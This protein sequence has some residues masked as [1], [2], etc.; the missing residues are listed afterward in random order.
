[1]KMSYDAVAIFWKG[2]FMKK[3]FVQNFTAFVISVSIMLVFGCASSVTPILQYPLL[4][5]KEDFA[6]V[7]IKN[8]VTGTKTAISEFIVTDARGE[9]KAYLPMLKDSMGTVALKAAYSWTPWGVATRMVHMNEGSIYHIPGIKMTLKVSHSR[10]ISSTQIGNT[11]HYKVGLWETY[12]THTFIAGK[13]YTIKSPSVLGGD[14]VI[15]SDDKDMT[16]SNSEI[17]YI[18][19]PEKKEAK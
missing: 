5:E 12:I 11:I 1:M 15:S 16:I 18:E 9:K 8:E 17:K 14:P 6:T 7:I 19:K 13:E 2:G 4:G 10:V 3:L